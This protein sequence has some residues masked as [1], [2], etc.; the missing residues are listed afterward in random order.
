[1]GQD[2]FWNGWS[3]AIS[4]YRSFSNGTD[5]CRASGTTNRQI[6]PSVLKR[7]APSWFLHLLTW[8]RCVFF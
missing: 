5:T 6:S 7:R 3:A 8:N 1:L 2:T 4:A